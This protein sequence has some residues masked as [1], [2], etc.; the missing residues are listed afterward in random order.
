M[1]HPN[2]GLVIGRRN[3]TGRTQA[4]KKKNVQGATSVFG[5][6]K[7]GRKEKIY[8]EVKANYKNWVEALVIY[9]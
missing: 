3:L 1:A 5:Y 7:W 2:T 8:Q 6:S 9:V 4:K